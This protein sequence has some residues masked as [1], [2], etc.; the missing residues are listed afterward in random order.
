MEQPVAV[1][2]P[3]PHAMLVAEFGALPA[4]KIL[5]GDV[6]RS[7]PYMPNFQLPPR[8]PHVDG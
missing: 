4:D 2:N 3:G 8:G 5:T 6:G 1:T 7:I